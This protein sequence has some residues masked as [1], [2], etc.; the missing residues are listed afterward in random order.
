MLRIRDYTRLTIGS[1]F[2]GREIVVCDHCK[3]PALLDDVNGKKWFTHSETIGFD[4][5][6]NPIMDWE[7]CPLLVPKKPPAAAPLG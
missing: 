6:G 5:V 2:D 7:T 4:D 3:K 1:K